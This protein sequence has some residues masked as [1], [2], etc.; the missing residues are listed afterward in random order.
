M[1]MFDW[2]EPDPPLPCRC[3]GI[4]VGLQGKNGPCELLVWREKHSAP[5]NQACDEKWR[6]PEEV[7]QRLRL[8]EVFHIYGSCR[9]CGSWNDFT[10]YTESG[11]WVHCVSGHF[12]A[13]DRCVGARDIGAGLRQC[14][15]CANWWGWP[16]ERRLSAC[17]D[18]HVLTTLVPA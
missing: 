3:G 13:L 5:L 11:T 8:P 14:T 4:V 2:Y 18:C 7:R 10:C 16:T 1:G 17:P 6:L 12:D 9:G 15:K